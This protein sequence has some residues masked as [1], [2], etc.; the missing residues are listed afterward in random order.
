MAETVSRLGAARRQ[1]CLAIRLFFSGGDAVSTHTLAC[2][3]HEILSVLSRHA[4]SI[5]ATSGEMQ[6]SFL[7]DNP[8]V[9]PE[10]KKEYLGVIK[11]HYNFFKHSG[12]DP[13]ESVDFNPEI[14]E[15]FLFD[16]LSMYQV[17]TKRWLYAG[18]LFYIWFSVTHPDTVKQDTPMRSLID[19]ILQT[20]R[21]FVDARREDYLELL[22]DKSILGSAGD[23]LD[24][25]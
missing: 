8:Y 20:P 14:T 24:D 3:A 15:Y 4:G 5:P 22:N 1:L 23:L 7:F 11:K 10:A 16:A 12:Q 13:H 2:A 25:C 6:G 18:L 9:R 19:K 21:G 17:V